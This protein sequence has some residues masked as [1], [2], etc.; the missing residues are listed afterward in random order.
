M[1]A[2]DAATGLAPQFD[3]LEQQH[4][5]DNL[6]MWAFLATELMFFGGLFASYA[7]YRNLYPEGF[8]A[9]SRHLSVMLGAINTAIL[10]TSSLT[11]ALAVRAAQIRRRHEAI[12]LLF[13]T[14]VLGAAF[15]GIK[16]FE[17]YQDYREHLIPG[18]GFRFEDRLRAS[19]QMFFL[20]YFL[21]TGLHAIHLIIGISLV[22]V[23]AALV[24]HDRSDERAATRVEITGLY[25]HFVDLV[26]VFLYPLLYL[27]DVHK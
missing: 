9:A 18:S 2:T 14:M 22:G 27:V 15:L 21:M 7:V 13:A 19:A 17:Y 16:A 1:T 23:I 25:W 6:G 20:I 5:T 4:L 8:I 12:W 10:L 11:M 24:R 3:D 26:W